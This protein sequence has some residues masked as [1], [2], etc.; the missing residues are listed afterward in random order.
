MHALMSRV[1]DVLR[2]SS[3]QLSIAGA[4]CER[5]RSIQSNE[6]VKEES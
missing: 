3:E 4:F 1:V 2:R 6:I 5:N